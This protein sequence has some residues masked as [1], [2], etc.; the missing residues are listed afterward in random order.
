MKRILPLLLL[1]I[2][3]PAFATWT[4]TGG[5]NAD[6]T[7]TDN[8]YATDGTWDLWLSRSG[9]GGYYCRNRSG[10]GGAVL[11]LTTFAEDM[12][13]AGVTWNSSAHYPITIIGIYNEGFMGLSGLKEVKLPSTIK[14][15]SNQCFRGTGLEGEFIVPD[16]VTSMG[17][18]VFTSCPSLTRIVMSESITA[19]QNTFCYCTAL[20]EVKLA[21]ETTTLSGSPFRGC[22]SLTTVYANDEDRVVGSV[23]LPAS[24]TTINSYAFC[25]D[26]LIERIV[27]PGVTSVAERAFQNCTSLSEVVLPALQQ[28]SSTYA[29]TGCPLLQRIEVPNCVKLGQATFQGC[30]T[31]EEVFVSPALNALGTDCFRDCTSFRT[32][33]TNAATKVVGYVQLPATCTGTI[34]NYTF[35]R[36][37]IKRIDA[38]GITSI[39]GQRAFEYCAELVEAHLPS[40]ASMSGTYAFN[41]CPLLTTV[42]VSPN[43]TGTI[44]DCNFS[45]CNSLESVYQAGTQPVVGLFDIPAGATKLGWGC[46]WNCK[47]MERFVGPGIVDIQN[48]AFRECVLLWT[49]RF[50]PDLAVIHNNNNNNDQTAFYGCTSLTDFYPSTMPKITEIRG[51]LFRD[52]S[53][54]TNAFDFSGSTAA[55]P[56]GGGASYLFSGAKKVPCV[57]LPATFTKLEDRAFYGMA[58]GAEIHFV[59]GVPSTSGSYQL[60]Q[61]Q[62]GAGNRYKIFV[63]ATTYPGWMTSAGTFTPVTEAMKSESDYPGIATLGYI[64]YASNNQNNWLV[65][66]P[67][68]VDVTFYDDD[69]TT[70]LDTVKTLLG[71]APAWTN[72]AP[73]KASTAQFDYEFAGWSTNGTTIVDLADFSVEAPMSF[74]AVYTPSTRSHTIT[75]QWF[76]GTAS[77]S[78]ATSVAYGDTPVHAAVERAATAEHTYTFQGWS[79]D[80]TTVLDPIPDVT[81]PA[82]YIAVFEEKDASTTVTVRWLDDNGTTVLATTWPDKGTVAEAPLVP[83]KESTISTTYAFAGWSTDGSTVLADLTV[84]ADTDFF[85]VYET[86]L[87]K[88]TV[89]F[90]NWDDAPILSQLYEYGTAA[91]DIVRP[92]TIPTRTADEGYTYAFTGWSPTI[93]DVSGDATYTA[94]YTATPKTYAA[95]FVD[96]DGA[97][98]SGP[99]DYAVGAAVEA[100]ADPERK[101]YT[102]T[103]WTPAV[104]TMSAADTT[105]TAT[106]TVN[107]YTI[108]FVNGDGV[109]TAKYDYG[110]PASSISFPGGSKTST[111]KFYYRF[112]K[113][114]PEAEP[115]QSNTTYTARFS[116]LVAKPMTLAFSDA[117]FDTGS[118]KIGIFATLAGA[119]ATG[120]SVVPALAAARFSASGTVGETF[121]GTAELDGNVYAAELDDLA[122]RMG[123]N[124]TATAEQDWPEYGTKDVAVLRGRSYARRRATWFDKMDV[125]WND[126][127]FKPAKTPPDR[128]QIRVRATFA[129]P[130]VP[131][132]TLP[133]AT[134]QIVGIGVKSYG[135]APAWHGWTGSAWVRL[136]GADPVGGGTVEILTVVDFAAKSPTATW[137][138]NGLPLTTEEGEWAVPLAGGIRLESFEAAGNL[139]AFSLSGDYDIGGEGFKLHVR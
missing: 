10:T 1:A 51:G 34:G 86:S 56:S 50:S 43:L 130:A 96:W 72:A 99:T 79:T 27:A 69:S 105:Y 91:A 58:P 78:D 87:R 121:N 44:G 15:L 48:R 66:E 113:W 84:S 126:G 71:T 31:L 25:D 83:S 13:D 110:T 8:F 3:A 139:E 123:Y 90:V 42:E 118:G 5:L 37:K 47:A 29:F 21:S 76:D 12:A 108:K 73:T 4:V 53:A 57:K 61:G 92:A 70:V 132:A 49:V 129:V 103:G 54:L 106:Y 95:T 89:A 120:A 115:V 60:W 17:D 119:T 26:V 124:W 125:S 19:P 111:S 55:Y 114:E 16:T 101:G 98:L 74:R 38:P 133:E 40:M 85:A 94:T 135:G 7:T 52:R 97:V 77:Q 127:V 116:A 80:G 134:G 2:A 22:S 63:D 36:T 102:F 6:G 109:S 18:N 41:G 35:Y 9:N 64:N 128:Q 100:P 131:P 33:Y 14:T 82:T 107:K 39:S 122:I 28:F 136:V 67:F 93:V 68:Y 75:W 62:N 45:G 117:V 46:F 23:V 24:V 32:L 137:Y 138:A 88:Y 30:S 11:D 65:Q 112:I 20:V 59:G 104:S 81:G